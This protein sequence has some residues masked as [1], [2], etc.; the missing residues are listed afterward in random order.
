MQ[1]ST[2]STSH[3]IYQSCQFDTTTTANGT[4]HA[5]NEKRKEKEMTST[6]TTQTKQSTTK[7]DKLRRIE[8]D[9]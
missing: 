4:D 2:I 6:S 5:E 1:C 8:I 7:R 3:T 9:M